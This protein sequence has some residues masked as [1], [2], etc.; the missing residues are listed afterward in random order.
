MSKIPSRMVTRILVVAFVCAA[1][2]TSASPKAP[3]NALR[4]F[5][6]VQLVM[7]WVTEAWP[8]SC[9][10]ATPPPPTKPDYA[11]GSLGSDADPNGAPQAA[12]NDFPVQGE[13]GPDAD[14]NG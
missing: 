4:A 3:A 8:C 9:Q 14:P 12:S 2:P 5:S 13:L 6:M 1:V 7:E 11:V 10:D